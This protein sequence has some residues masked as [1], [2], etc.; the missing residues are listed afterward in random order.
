MKKPNPLRNQQGFTLI[1]IIAVLIILGIL[2]AVVVPRYFEL[3]V[4][5]K[6]RSLEA[7]VAELN[8]RESRVWAETKISGSGTGTDVMKSMS[9]TDKDSHLY[10]GKD[11]KWAAPPNMDGTTELDFQGQKANV[12]R[13]PE[14]D[15]QPAIWK[16]AHQ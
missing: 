16:L 2:A 3:E 10:L 7:A 6:K 1:E 11:Y 13:T 14:T 8:S 5:S 4:I 9:Y 15:T 12:T